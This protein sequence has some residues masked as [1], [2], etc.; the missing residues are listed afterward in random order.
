MNVTAILTIEQ[1]CAV[2]QA[3]SARTPAVVSV[4]AGRIADT[5]VDPIPMM[6]RAKDILAP[7]PSTELLWASCREAL[8]IKHAAEAGCD[9]ITVPHEILKKTSFFGKCLAE[10][11]LETVQMFH[12]DAKAAGFRL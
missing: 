5:G 2:H 1:V 9:I 7:R 8:N 11:S 6:R 4:F 3:L 10:L 12:E